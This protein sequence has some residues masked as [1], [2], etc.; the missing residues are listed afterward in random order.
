MIVHCLRAKVCRFVFCNTSSTLAPCSGQLHTHPH[1]LP[2]RSLHRSRTWYQ[3]LHP[4]SHWRTFSSLNIT[5]R[6]RGTLLEILKA[7]VSLAIPCLT[8]CGSNLEIVAWATGV[9]WPVHAYRSTNT[10][11]WLLH[12]TYMCKQITFLNAFSFHSVRFSAFLWD[13]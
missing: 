3:S 12:S 8:K 2:A 1:S 13:I 4:S 9:S 7:R 11:P 6:K 5:D 10:T